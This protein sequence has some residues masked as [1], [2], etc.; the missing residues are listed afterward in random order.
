MTKKQIRR[1]VLINKPFQLTHAGSLMVVQLM[2]VL[3]TGLVVSCF[4]LF[5]QDNRL[6]CNHNPAI[7]YTMSAVLLVAWC[8][9]IIWSIKYT[10]SIAGPI[11]KIRTILKN[12]EKGDY[13]NAPI[14]FRK[15]DRFKN[16]GYPLG[17]CLLK[18]KNSQTQMEN[19]VKDIKTLQQ[20]LKTEKL[21]IDACEKELQGILDK[22][23]KQ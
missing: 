22:N 13:P 16:I 10:H 18:M 21:T 19:T 11:Y 3:F 7:F 4:Y 2:S 12:A 20:R 23:E 5:L 17:V 14:L 9:M 15:N 1:R 8:A 6:V